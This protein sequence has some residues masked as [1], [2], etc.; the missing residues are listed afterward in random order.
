MH[1]TVRK[2]ATIYHLYENFD[3]I[4]HVKILTAPYMIASRAILEPLIILNNLNN[5]SRLCKLQ[6][7][8]IT[9]A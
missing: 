3:H 5:I 2:Q 9:Q 8:G 1:L 4:I 6:N 7:I